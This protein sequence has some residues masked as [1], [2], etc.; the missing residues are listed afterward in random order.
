MYVGAPHLVLGLPG[1]HD[2][3]LDGL[4]PLP[5]LSAELPDLRRG[6]Q[7]QALVRLSEIVQL[8]LRCSNGK[9]K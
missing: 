2:R 9:R 5:R 4:G 1:G 8:R 3:I 6:L 7:P